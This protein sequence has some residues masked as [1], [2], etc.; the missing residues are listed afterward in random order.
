MPPSET[1]TRIQSITEA[2]IYFERIG[3]RLREALY[4]IQAA[5][6]A[7]GNGAVAPALTLT[8]DPDA[9]RAE[10]KLKPRRRAKSGPKPARLPSGKR[11]RMKITP[12]IVTEIRMR[13][14]R[15]V[16]QAQIAESLGI[17]LGT[18]RNHLKKG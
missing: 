6:D 5:P 2:A 1:D 16:P 18:V 11:K 17:S 3:S 7:P 10:L 9:L 15:G 13:S 14:S 4:L 8:S 12:E